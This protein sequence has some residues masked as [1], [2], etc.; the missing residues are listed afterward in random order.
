MTFPYEW[1]GPSFNPNTSDLAGVSQAT[2]QAWLTAAQF[3]MAELASGSKVATVSI[4]QG[5][6]NRS[7]TFRS[8][9]MAVLSQWI[10]LLKAQLGMC[11]SRRR[12]S[13]TVFF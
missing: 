10:G 12:P 9:N 2:L 11:G 4:A 7:V 13:S 1:V 5:D 8:N 3:A 6:S